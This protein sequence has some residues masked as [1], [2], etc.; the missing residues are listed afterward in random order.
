MC[1]I[2]GIVGKGPVAPLLVD[3]LKRLEYFLLKDTTHMM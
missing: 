3:G 1:G 2:I